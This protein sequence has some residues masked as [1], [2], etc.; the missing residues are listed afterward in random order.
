MLNANHGM[1]R[2]SSTSSDVKGGD[3]T[4]QQDKIMEIHSQML[5]MIEILGQMSAILKTIE[6]WRCS[7]QHLSVDIGH[8]ATSQRE[9]TIASAFSHNKPTEP[10]D[11]QLPLD[12]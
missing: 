6:T 2:L 11:S 9:F 12:I 10:L 3:N 8:M 5:E 4:S 7:M 1:R